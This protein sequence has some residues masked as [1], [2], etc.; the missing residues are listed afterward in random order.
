MPN[1]NSTRLITTAFVLFLLATSVWAGGIKHPSNYGDT[2]GLGFT[3][4]GCGSTQKDGVIAE[5][6]EGNGGFP[7]DF[8]F[9]FSL[10][11]PSLSTSISSVTFSF[12]ATDVAKL[13]PDSPPDSPFGLFQD[14]PSPDCNKMNVKCT[15]PQVTFTANAL[16]LVVGDNKFLFGNFTGDLSGKVTAFFSFTDTVTA[17]KFIDASLSSTTTV[18]EPSELG[19][20]ITALG[21][22]IIVRRRQQRAKQN[23]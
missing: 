7:H 20:L 15:P 4:L 3:L 23:G 19:L 16:P 21:S 14:D 10:A 12:D 1:Q 11:N 6:F 18:P 13:S 17:P 5:C 8:L 2:S 9:T 22:I